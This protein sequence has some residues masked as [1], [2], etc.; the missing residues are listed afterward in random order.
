MYNHNGHNNHTKE[1]K[2]FYG[3]SNPELGKKITEK[4]GIAE[5]KVNLKKFASGEIY[6][7]FLE[8]I[9]GDD[10]FLMQTAVDPVNDHL[11]ELLIMIDA[12]KRASAGR[13]VVVMPNY[14]YARQDRKAASREPITAKLIADL[15]TIAGADRV[16]TI[17]LHSDQIQGFFNIPFDN[18]PASTTL[19]EKAKELV[20]KDE[21]VIVAPDAGE[22]KKATKTAM[23]MNLELSIINKV[24]QKH[25]EA[26]ALNIIGADVKGKVCLVFDDMVD[27]GGSL[28]TTAEMLKESGARK[29][30]ALTTHG[31]L[32]G[33]AVE[34]IEA[35]QIDK[36]I[37]CDTLPL[38][39]KS[40]KI[41]IVSVA[42]YLANAIKCIHADESVSTLFRE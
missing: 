36:L 7:Q 40:K 37:I 38:R 26:K 8:N 41:E 10:V 34:K 33:N 16:I 17:D 6:A 12:A 35:S 32:S 5:G 21:A 13:I 19:I 4:L 20:G 15:L 24:R 25:N 30:Y 14:F 9:R 18:L 11:V 22:A 3:S 1:L 27:T 2:F 39:Q 23:R 28:C 29:I 42:E 31:V